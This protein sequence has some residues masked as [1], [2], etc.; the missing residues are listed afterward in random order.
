MTTENRWPNLPPELSH[1]PMAVA[2]WRDSLFLEIADHLWD[3]MLT[4]DEK[5]DLVQDI[6]MSHFD[7][8]DCDEDDDYLCDDCRAEQQKVEAE[9]AD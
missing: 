3:K 9:A 8:G 1:A 6:V 5:V 4:S 7:H 2:N